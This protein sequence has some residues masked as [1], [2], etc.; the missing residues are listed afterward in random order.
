MWSI[1]RSVHHFKCAEAF[2]PIVHLDFPVWG[3]TWSVCLNPWLSDWPERCRHSHSSLLNMTRRMKG[4]SLRGDEYLSF[5]TASDFCCFGIY[6]R[7]WLVFYPEC[8]YKI[9]LPH[10]AFYL[11]DSGS[12]GFH[13]VETSALMVSSRLLTPS[14]LNCG[15]HSCSF[16]LKLPSNYEIC[17]IQN[18]LLSYTPPWPRFKSVCQIVKATGRLEKPIFFPLFFHYAVLV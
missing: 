10:I 9:F 6:C 16:T 3:L 14:K 2:E 18:C 4:F 17:Y 8:A 7:K 1:W 12:G 13:I 5:Y 15:S 11:Y